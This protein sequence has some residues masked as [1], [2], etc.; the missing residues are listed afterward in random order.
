MYVHTLSLLPEEDV[1]EDP[2]DDSE[3]DPTVPGDLWYRARRRAAGSGVVYCGM[4]R[5][6]VRGHRLDEA[7]TQ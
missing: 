5:H 3:A 2:D 4:A 1:L 6:G 7:F